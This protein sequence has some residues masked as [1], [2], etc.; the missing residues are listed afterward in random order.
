LKRSNVSQ[1]HAVVLLA[2]R[3]SVQAVEAE[4]LDAETL[5]TYLKLEQ[6]IPKN[7]FFTVELTCDSNFPVLNS[8]IL[9]RANAHA[10]HRTAV[11]TGTSS[12]T[13]STSKANSG[14]GSPTSHSMNSHSLMTVDH[15]ARVIQATQKASHAFSKTRLA[16]KLQQQQA[17]SSPTDATGTTT[18]AAV[19]A[20]ASATATVNS[21]SAHGHALIA[22]IDEDEGEDTEENEVQD[23][24][25]TRLAVANV[26]DKNGSSHN[27]NSRSMGEYEERFEFHPSLR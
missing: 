20:T 10:L 7:V 16:K 12:H 4:N 22:S 25:K 6:Y 18:T 11:G 9:R 15:H 5:F 3:D 19:T 13:A 23:K 2:S 26:F 1:A 21:G 8:T 14:H 27:H 24:D 17:T